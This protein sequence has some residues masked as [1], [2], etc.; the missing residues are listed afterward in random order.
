MYK[1]PSKIQLPIKNILL[2]FQH[3]KFEFAY[4][5]FVFLQLPSDI[6]WREL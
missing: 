3:L 2:R 4:R 5:N 6:S 1:K